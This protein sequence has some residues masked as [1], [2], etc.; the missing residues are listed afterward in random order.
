MGMPVKFNMPA[1]NGVGLLSY[2]QNLRITRVLC[3]CVVILLLNSF[4]DPSLA[5]SSRISLNVA[6]V[7]DLKINGLESEL[8]KANLVGFIGGKGLSNSEGRT[9]NFLGTQRLLFH[10]GGFNFYLYLQYKN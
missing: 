10:G 8:A 5:H 1:S 7:S 3:I 2:R 6:G 9:R 4:T